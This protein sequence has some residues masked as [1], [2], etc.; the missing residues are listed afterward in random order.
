M[1]D[2]AS[3][4]DVQGVVRATV[5]DD[6]RF[7]VVEHPLNRGLYQARSTASR[8][9]RG[10]YYAHVDSD[11]YIHPRFAEIMV[12]EALTTGA[13]IVECKAIELGE[14]GRPIRFNEILQEGPVDGAF[15][16]RDFFANRL[17]NVVWNKL[18]SRD[19]WHRAPEHLQIDRGLTIC[20]DLLRNALIFPECRRYAAVED[21][22]YFYCRRPVSVVKGGNLA[23]LVAKLRDV[24]FAYATALAHLK[25]PSRAEVWARLE[26]RH[27]EDVQWYVG[28]YLD[29]H[30]FDQVLA[31]AQRMGAA[32]DPNV[33]VL[34]HLIR[35]RGRLK[36]DHARV[37]RAWQQERNRANQLDKRLAELGKS[38]ER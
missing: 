8:E 36:A 24:D 19:L 22:L 27:A 33:L 26:F 4:G 17:R 31:E 38:M 6:A 13:E 2:D 21:C 7:R 15:A 18:Y 28:E 11:D 3:P 10:L 5:G 30:D 20:E 14:E 35:G 32:L 37:T 34:L 23:R 9:A 1:V 12:N 29:R 25:D 16:A